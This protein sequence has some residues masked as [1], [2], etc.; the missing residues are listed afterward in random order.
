MFLKLFHLLKLILIISKF[1]FIF[2]NVYAEEQSLNIKKVNY[3]NILMYHRFGET[4]HPSTNKTPT[5]YKSY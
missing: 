2:T 4:T 5:I 1:I 3:A